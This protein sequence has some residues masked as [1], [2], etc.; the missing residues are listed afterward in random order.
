MAHTHQ[1]FRLILACLLY[2]CFVDPRAGQKP[3]PTRWISPTMERVWGS[4]FSLLDFFQQRFFMQMIEQP[5][6]G[7]A[8]GTE[9]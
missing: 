7:L 2:K 8:P 9:V 5:G 4:H 1:E 3:D 6:A